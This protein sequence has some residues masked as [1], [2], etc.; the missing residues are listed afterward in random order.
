MIFKKI[1]NFSV[2]FR[3]HIIAIWLTALI[4]VTFFAPDLGQVS[5]SDQAGFL[6]KNAPSVRATRM[7]DHYFSGHFASSSAILVFDIPDGSAYDPPVKS[8]LSEFT[9]WIKTDLDPEYIGVILSPDDPRIAPRLI[10]PDGRVALMSVGIKGSY[11]DKAVVNILKSMQTK[12]ENSPYGIKG[13][14]TGAI[15]ITNAYKNAILESAIKTTGI[16]VILVI[17]ILLLIYRSPV[18]P[19]VSLFTIGAA[20]GISRGLCAWLAMHGMVISTMTDLFLVVLLFG[21]GTDY[22]LFII[23]RYREYMA[24]NIN[25]CDSA[26]AAIGSVGETITSSVGTVIVAVIAVS[27]V[28][29]KLFSNTGPSLAIG[30]T[31]ALFAVMTLSPAMLA[32]LGIRAFWPG[33]PEHAHDSAIWGRIAGMVT[34]YPAA[35]LVSGVMILLPLAIYGQGQKLTFDMLVDLPADE[36]SKAGYNVI[37]KAFGAGQMQPVELLAIVIDGSRKPA[38]ISQIASMTQKL[39]EIP[40]VSDVDSLTRPLGRFKPHAVD[41]M[42]VDFQLKRIADKVGSAHDSLLNHTGFDP[43]FSNDTIGQL[44]FIKL[45]LCDL[46]NAF[47]DL[48]LNRNYHG[49]VLSLSRLKQACADSFKRL[50]LTDQLTEIAAQ[51]GN[52]KSQSLDV[53]LGKMISRLNTLNDYLTG[54]SSA[55]QWADRLNG[56]TG[57]LE[58]LGVLRQRLTEIDSLSSAL[59]TVELIRNRKE[60]GDLQLKLSD[61]LTEMK[62][63]AYVK[64]PDVL[65]NPSLSSQEEQEV[66]KSILSE[67]EN[68]SIALRGLGREFAHRSDGYF[69]PL[70]LARGVERD[71][72]LTILDT[73]TSTTGE[74]ARYRVFLTDEPYSP[75]AMDT[76]VRL[77]NFSDTVKTYQ[78][79]G[80]A[81]LSDLR[82]AMNK[83]TRLMWILVSAGIILVLVVLL[84]SLVA[85]LYLMATIVLSYNATMGITRLVFNTF[86]NQSLTWFVPF[87]MFVLLMALGMDYNIFLMGRVKEEV[88]ENGT[89]SGV[90]RAVLLTGGII[91]SAGIIMAGTFT[92]M[93]SSSLLGLVQLGFAVTVGVLLDTFVVRT[94]IVPA[95]VVLLGKWNWWPGKNIS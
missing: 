22:S 30:L 19:L 39:L 21:A 11:E 17:I 5:V 62:K 68:F 29:L 90:R 13:Y 42:R 65:Y 93:M 46:G 63:D 85:P 38:G 43:A 7:L 60:L 67:M 50:R 70:N 86:L 20:Y 83:D 10:S 4:M 66:L 32:V 78:T 77:N 24:D 81:I 92:A 48:P 80:T 69:L 25:P 73:Y 76:V 35:T 74:A 52:N 23:S 84:R 56:Y 64:M 87:F 89:E 41:E 12:I 37:K 9:A 14:V 59:R 82:D 71:S 49:A 61:N 54:L 6:D 26:A 57:S 44:N 16:T 55:V 33:K 18:L 8:Y 28:S 91:T 36:S 47:S 15:P 95:I 3:F 27:F 51:V 40:G 1:G 53:D 88:S 72:I 34:R 79:G 75:S 45:Y 58:T 31:I 94:S 2:K